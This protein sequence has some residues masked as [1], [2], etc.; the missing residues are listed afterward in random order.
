MAKKIIYITA[1]QRKIGS[2]IS[3]FLS[4]SVASF[5]MHILCGTEWR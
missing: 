5:Q 1:Q 4:H 3:S 2:T